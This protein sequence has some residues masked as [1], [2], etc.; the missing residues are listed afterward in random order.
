MMAGFGLGIRYLTGYAVATHPSTREKAE[1]PPHPGRVFMA[2]AAAHFETEEDPLERTALEWLE[3]LGAPVLLASDADQRTAVTH[4]VPVNDSAG[5]SKAPLQSAPALTRDRVGRTFPC[6]RPHHDTVSLVWPDAHP[7]PAH[8]QALGQLCA[9]VIRLGHSS[10]FVQMWYAEQPAADGTVLLPTDHAPEVSLRIVAQGTLDYLRR[11]YNREA[12]DAFAQLSQRIAGSRGMARQ[13]VK[14]E[15]ERVFGHP[16]KTSIPPPRVQRPVLSLWQGY[17]RQGSNL[18]PIPSQTVFDP[19]LI[20]LR[21]EPG[22][23]SF[24]RLDLVTTLAVTDVLRRAIQHVADRDL[25]LAPIPEVLTGHTADGGPSERPHLAW[26]PLAF[27]GRPHAGGHLMGLAAA[28]PR[29]EHWPDHHVERRRVLTALARV[30]ELTLGRLG[31]WAVIPELR[32]A[33]PYNLAPETWTAA[34]SGSRIWASVTPVAFDE[35]PK[36][37]DRASYHEAVA[38]MVAR[39]CRRI[40]L[41]EPSAVRG[42]AVS[43]HLGVPGAL[44]FPRLRRKDGSQRRHTHVFL[45]FEHPVVGPV[46]LGAGRYRGYGLFRPL[47]RS[48]EGTL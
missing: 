12:V 4:F 25:R 30:G 9:K 45:E 37:R 35:H 28:L 44:E 48:G 1:W 23:S 16:W 19:R 32:Q 38:A 6:V 24:A 47:W 46:V 11:Q 27:V 5:P 40:G 22:R 2:L 42:E 33:P 13:Q 39:A 34:P 15:F 26:L 3:T 43:A 31:V 18:M 36:G 29:E 20:V 10:S 7:S 17:R 14:A 41:P 21:L 8:A